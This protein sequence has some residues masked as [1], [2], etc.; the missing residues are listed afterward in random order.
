MFM[1]QNNTNIYGYPPIQMSMNQCDSPYNIINN[2]TYYNNL[3]PEKS[4]LIKVE[5]PVI[6]P[7]TFLGKSNTINTINIPGKFPENSFPNITEESINEYMENFKKIIYSNNDIKDSSKKSILKQD[8]DESNQNEIITIKQKNL[9][10]NGKS[11]CNE[12]SNSKT[13]DTTP[14]TE[15]NCSKL[16]NGNSKDKIN[17][18][19]KFVFNENEIGKKMTSASLSYYFDFQQKNVKNFKLNLVDNFPY[20]FENTDK[21]KLFNDNEEEN[22]IYNTAKIIDFKS[23]SEDETKKYQNFFGPHR[24]TVIINLGGMRNTD[25]EEKRSYK[26]Y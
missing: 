25:R 7:S 2:N 19:S 4:S 17:T 23:E 16:L 5:P 3:A 15:S 18:T 1:S 26:P 10:P 24:S 20:K 22:L 14:P 11:H 13:I 8:L 12:I 9:I 6:I 21:L